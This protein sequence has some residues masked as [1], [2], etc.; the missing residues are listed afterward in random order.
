MSTD[1]HDKDLT[2]E[3]LFT[4]ALNNHPNQLVIGEISSHDVK[5]LEVL[6][7]LCEG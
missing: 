4:K 3:Q 6:R 7:R 2:L 5:E 1:T